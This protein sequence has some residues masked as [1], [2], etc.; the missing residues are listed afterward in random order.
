MF[1][2]SL[3][4][5]QSYDQTVYLPTTPVGITASKNIAIFFCSSSKSLLCD[6]LPKEDFRAQVATALAERLWSKNLVLLCLA[7]FKITNGVCFTKG[8]ACL[9][10]WPEKMKA[11]LNRY[12][13]TPCTEREHRPVVST[14]SER[15]VQSSQAKFPL[16]SASLN[17]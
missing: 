13:S 2:M 11:G 4:Q 3:F 16:S 10:P 14:L 8:L 7:F 12:G 9:C 17:L 1:V 15:S 5:P 6:L